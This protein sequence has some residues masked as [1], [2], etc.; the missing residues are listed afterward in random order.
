M[1][2]SADLF[3]VGNASRD[4]DR[5]AGQA[6][7]FADLVGGL[8]YRFGDTLAV[9]GS[10]NSTKLLLDAQSPTTLVGLWVRPGRFRIRAP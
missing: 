10:G 2:G 9:Q 5:Q 3:E 8:T 1:P 6:M 4:Y 7:R